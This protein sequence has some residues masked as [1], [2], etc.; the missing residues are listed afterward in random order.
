MAVKA[1]AM[2][3]ELVAVIVVHQDREDQEDMGR[4]VTMDNSPFMVAAIML[5]LQTLTAVHNMDNKSHWT[6]IR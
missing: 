4:R 6:L 2:E 3:V 5:L 1:T